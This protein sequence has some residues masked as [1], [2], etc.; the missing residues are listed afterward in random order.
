M[1]ST[2]GPAT[3]PMT[4]YFPDPAGLMIARTG[5]TD[6]MQADAGDVVATMKLG[7]D[8]FGNHEHYDA[9]HFQIYYK[10][11]L[12]IDRASTAAATCSTLPSR[13]NTAVRMT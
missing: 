5:W 6:A 1:G 13:W 2:P 12:A 3:L 7:G 4:K 9:G 10:G 11:G 8:W